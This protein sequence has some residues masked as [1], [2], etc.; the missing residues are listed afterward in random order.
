MNKLYSDKG[1][2]S[3]ALSRELLKK[4]VTLV[5]NVRKNMKMKA[6]SLWD[7][8]MLSRRFTIETINNQLKNIS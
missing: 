1:D 2:I 8:A 5:K 6:I 7:R 3:K 4:D